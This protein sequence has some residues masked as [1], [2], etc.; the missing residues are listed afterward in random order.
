LAGFVIVLSVSAVLVW[1]ANNGLSDSLERER[2][3]S[4]YQRIALSEREWSAN[5]L[6]RVEQL[7]E[8]CPAD[9]RGWE[10]HYLKR[11]RDTPLSALYDGNI[12]LCVAFS[13][14]G[15]FLA[16][17]GRDGVI[18]VWDAHTGQLVRPFQV[19]ENMVFSLAFSP[20][21]QRLAAACSDGWVK[22]W[23]LQT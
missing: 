23:D 8:E 5:N 15:Q 21:G 9:L 12:V 13:P 4:Y 2:Q 20:D 14:I 17:A 1:R 19:S 16:S 6:S 11:R 22:I 7:L 18:K 10:W 3:N